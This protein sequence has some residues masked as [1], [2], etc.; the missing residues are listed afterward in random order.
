MAL[1]VALAAVLS[2]AFL[3]ALLPVLLSEITDGDWRRG[4]GALV[5]LAGVAGF[6]LVN[7][8]ERLAASSM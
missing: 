7:A 5:V 6:L 8:G 3:V 1:L 4:L 2:T